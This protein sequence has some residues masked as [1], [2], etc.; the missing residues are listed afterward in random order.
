MS[1]VF[2]PDVPVKR[3]REWRKVHVSPRTDRL[4]GPVI[5]ILMA[6]A[7]IYGIT[8]IEWSYTGGITGLP[9]WVW[10]H[11]LVLVL[12]Y[13]RGIRTGRKVQ[14][15][16]HSYAGVFKGHMKLINKHH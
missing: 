7:A 6:A 4:A 8:Q 11:L 12:G 15:V 9:W 13:R 5:A 1:D 14:A 16:V 2:Y 10:S 3:K